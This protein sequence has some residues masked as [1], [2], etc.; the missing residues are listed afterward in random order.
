MSATCDPVHRSSVRSRPAIRAVRSSAEF[1]LGQDQP[2]Q[3]RTALTNGVA[4]SRW[5]LPG[6]RR[7]TCDGRVPVQRMGGKRTTVLDSSVNTSTR[8]AMW[9]R[10]IQPA[11]VRVGHSHTKRDTLNGAGVRSQLRVSRVENGRTDML[12]PDQGP[13]LDGD[14]KIVS[15][16]PE[17]TG[18]RF[19]VLERDMVDTTT[20]TDRYC[21]GR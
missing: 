16:V 5:K 2:P 17:E 15:S 7:T 19:V 14:G 1:V 11:C 6:C 9:L 12:R 3:A 4:S 21:H 13:K 20:R 8:W 10:W 18:V